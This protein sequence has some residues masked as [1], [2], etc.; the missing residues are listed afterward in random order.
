MLFDDYE[1]NLTLDKCRSQFTEDELQKL[2]E[3][4]QH[5]VVRQNYLKFGDDQSEELVDKFN[6]LFRRWIDSQIRHKVDLNGLIVE[7][8]ILPQ[9]LEARKNF[10]DFFMIYSAEEGIEKNI[11]IEEMFSLPKT[12]DIP[13]LYLTFIQGLGL[14]ISFEQATENTGNLSRMIYDENTAL[15][16]IT[17]KDYSQALSTKKNSHAYL[18][19][20]DQLQL[21]KGEDGS[22]RLDLDH[23]TE[24][25]KK[26]RK[27]SIPASSVDSNLIAALAAAVRSSYV[28]NLGDVVTVD[29]TSFAKA[30][31]T[32]FEK[33]DATNKSHFDFWGKI[34]Q[35]TNIGGYLVKQG[36]ILPVFKFEKYDVNRNELTFASPYLYAIMDILKKEPVARTTEKKKNRLLFEDIPGLSYLTDARIIKAPGKNTAEVVKY[37]IARLF[38][39][40]LPPDAKRYPHKQF[41][42]EKL[43]TLTIT[44]KECVKNVQLLKE[45]LE[46]SEPKRRSRNLFGVIFGKDYGKKTYTPLVEKY[47]REYTDAFSY[48]KDLTIKVEPVSMKE[49]DNKII[50]T[51]HGLNGNFKKRLHVPIRHHRAVFL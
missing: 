38:Q 13:G 9:E 41:E 4:G 23:E 15:L 29:L 50:L 49:L 40:G 18:V 31:E 46:E 33:Q 48:W 47:L 43:I 44:Y 17:H 2:Q 11:S 8:D 12:F 24:E 20:L 27:K 37:I 25:Q 32:Q 30:L 34:N 42:D 5:I 51:H 39:H 16:Q 45:Y 35:L 14:D 22:Y 1:K 6:S 26:S 3:F 28:N 21:V 10:P 19:R 7:M 36:E